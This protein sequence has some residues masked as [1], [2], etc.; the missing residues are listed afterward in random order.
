MEGV[1]QSHD[2]R[3]KRRWKPI[4]SR[5][6]MILLLCWKLG[7]GF[8][9][10][11]SRPIFATSWQ[12]DLGSETSFFQVSIFATARSMGHCHGVGP[13]W[14]SH[15]IIIFF[16]L[17]ITQVILVSLF[18]L[19]Y[20]KQTSLVFCLGDCIKSPALIISD[21]M[22]TSPPTVSQILST[23]SPLHPCRLQRLLWTIFWGL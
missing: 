8:R 1:I 18:K 11:D 13:S 17:H 20:L 15:L 14:T 19:W 23:L 21:P 4:V 6:W 22:L 12:C 7:T 9:R 2:C 5:P 10:I 16:K 3:S